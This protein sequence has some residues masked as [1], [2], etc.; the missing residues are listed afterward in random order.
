[1]QRTPAPVWAGEA[2]KLLFLPAGKRPVR[3]WLFV[4]VRAR[5][6]RPA[7]AE[8]RPRT[9]AERTACWR[10]GAASLATSVSGKVAWTLDVE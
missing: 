10:R 8:N 1:M 2:W 9:S 5:D 7:R 3:D 4:I 6:H